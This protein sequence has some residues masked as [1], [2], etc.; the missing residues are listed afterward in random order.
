MNIYI[1]IKPRLAVKSTSFCWGYAE[2]KGRTALVSATGGKLKD[3]GPASAPHGLDGGT[4][5]K[6]DHHS[7]SGQRRANTSWLGPRNRWVTFY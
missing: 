1:I 4:G 7:A 6:G 2:A 5:M 3:K